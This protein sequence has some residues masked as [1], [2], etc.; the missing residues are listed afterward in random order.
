MKQLPAGHVC[1]ERCVCP[2]HPDLPLILHQDRI[3]HEHA[4]QLA[5][6]QFGHGLETR[7]SELAQ[8]CRKEGVGPII[9]VVDEFPALL[10]EAQKTRPDD[11]WMRYQ[12]AFHSALTEY[13]RSE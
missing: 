5:D 12:R 7:L 13:R 10:A 2:V 1:D 3:G 4:C 9:L 11:S 6:C 8:E